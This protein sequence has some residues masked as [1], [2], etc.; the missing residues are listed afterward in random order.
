MKRLIL[1]VM[2]LV[3][4]VGMASGTEIRP[5]RYGV[6]PQADTFLSTGRSTDGVTVKAMAK[7]D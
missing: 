3:A 2:L 1:S 4:A 7:P 5:D 6:Y